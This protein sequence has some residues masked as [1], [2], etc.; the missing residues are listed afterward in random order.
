LTKA[1]V[2][3][4]E[5]LKE[6][7]YQAFLDEQASRSPRQ[8]KI[9]CISC[10]EVLLH[11]NNRFRPDRSVSGDML[12]FL[13][14]LAQAGYS[15]QFGPNDCGDAIQ[16]PACGEGLVDGSSFRF[17]EGVLVDPEDSETEESENINESESSEELESSSQSKGK[18]DDFKL[19]ELIDK[20]KNQVEIAEYFQCSKQAVNQRL[21]TLRES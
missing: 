2:S 1:G 19:L 6:A 13:P 11:T 10:G 15:I 17:K 16:C 8:S 18:I 9:R 20:G 7:A 4:A 12:E 21:K 14:D 5:Q 3:M